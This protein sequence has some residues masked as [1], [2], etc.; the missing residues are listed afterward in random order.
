MWNYNYSSYYFM[1]TAE[2]ISGT[3]GFLIVDILR[4]CSN[5]FQ[6]GRNDGSW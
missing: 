6:I 3:I 1:E 4:L 2:L 5:N